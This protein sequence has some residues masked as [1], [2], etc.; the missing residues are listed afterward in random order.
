MPII[1]DGTVI[2]AVGDSGGSVEQD[3]LVAR[4]A[5]AGIK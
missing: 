4:A 3:I 2:G 5:L 1:V